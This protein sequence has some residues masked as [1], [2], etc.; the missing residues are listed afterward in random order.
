M[1]EIK[2]AIIGLGNMGRKYAQDIISKKVSGIKLVAICAR[3]PEQVNWIHQNI[4]TDTLIFPS[5]ESLFESNT[6]DAV[7][8]ST[9]HSSHPSLAIQAFEKGLHVLI[10]KPAGIYTKEVKEMNNAAKKAG[11]VF[12]IMHNQRTNP[13]YLKLKNL[14]TTGELGEIRRVNWIVTSLYRS[15][16]YYDSDSWRGTWAGEGGGVLITQAYHQ[17][18]LLQWLC[19]MPTRVRAFMGFGKMHDI[20]VEDDVTAYLEYK[21]GATGVFIASTCDTPGTNR[22]EITGDGGKIVIEDNSFEF[23]KLRTPERKFNQE[24]TGGFGEPECFKCTVPIEAENTGRIGI[25]QN[26]VEAIHK[27]TPLLAPGEEG[28]L[29]LMLVNA[30]H[31]SAWTDHWVNLPINEDLFLKSLQEKINHLS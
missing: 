28:I 18:D 10:E 23:W 27:N 12:G 4:G 26:W 6:V 1:I 20:E 31:L 24:Y 30:M 29:G 11:T 19:G 3:N 25:L 7:L 5:A 16:S 17:L 21:N 13:L 15:Q 8:I 22:L 9:P 2:L 14:I